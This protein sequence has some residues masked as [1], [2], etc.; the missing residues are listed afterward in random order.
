MFSADDP[1]LEYQSLV[2][3]VREITDGG[4]DIVRFFIEAMQG[5]NDDAMPCH[6][7]DAVEQLLDC[8]SHPGLADFVREKTD[9]GR[10]IVRVLMVLMQGRFEGGSQRDRDEARQMLCDI[11][12]GRTWIPL[13]GPPEE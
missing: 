4:R 11:F 3:Y 13:A 5:E 8:G 10:L 1:Q 6:R 7:L 2:E 12:E 9:D